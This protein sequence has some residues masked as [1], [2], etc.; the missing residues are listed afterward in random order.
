MG[1]VMAMAAVAVVVAWSAVQ[2]FREPVESTTTAPLQVREPL[3]PPRVIKKVDP[4][5]PPEARQAGIQGTVVLES[6]V[7]KD[8][9]VHVRRVLQGIDLGLDAQAVRAAEQWRFEPATRN[10]EPVDMVIKLEI[11]FS[12]RERPRLV[13]I[14]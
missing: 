10:G 4:V 13:P 2:G 3:T 12:L 8:G 9:S 7:A 6:L 1:L 14:R 11:N 5:I